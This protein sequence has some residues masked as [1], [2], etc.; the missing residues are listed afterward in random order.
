MNA[1]DYV[2]LRLFLAELTH[3]HVDEKDSRVD[4]AIRAMLERQPDAA[5]L[6]VGRIMQLENELC[7]ART[8]GATPVMRAIHVAPA[9]APQPPERATRWQ[10]QPPWWLRPAATF[11][12]VAFLARSAEHLLGPWT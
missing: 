8:T 3:A 6:L 5:Y 10:V 9:D 7:V 2:Q 1:V 11:T 12:G 4:A